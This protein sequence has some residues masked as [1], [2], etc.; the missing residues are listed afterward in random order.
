VLGLGPGDP[1]EGPPPA[2]DAER[3]AAEPSRG[4][5]GANVLLVVF[6]AARADHLGCYGYRQPT[7]PALDRLAAEGVLFERHFT[8][9]VFT[10][11]AM[12][13]LWS[14]R[15]PDEGELRWR[16]DGRLPGDR[17]TLAE[18]LASH[19]ILTAAFVT[20]PSA[21]PSYGLVRGFQQVQLLY[22][23]PWVERAMLPKA[24]VFRKH[25]YPWLEQ[26]RRDRFFVYAHWR[27]PHGPLDEPPLTGPDAPLPPEAHGYQW[28]HPVNAGKRSLSPA[29]RDHLERLYDGNLA[30]A[31]REFGA[32]RR[33][34]EELGL[35]DH[36]VV[37]ATADHGEALLEHGTYGHNV[38]VYQESM[39]IPL[40]VRFPEGAGPAGRRVSRLT[41]LLDIAPTVA[42]LFGLLGRGGS[43]RAFEGRSLLP[44]AIGPPEGPGDPGLVARTVTDVYGLVQGHH[45]LVYDSRNGRTEL[46][47]LEVDPRERV[48]LSGREPIRAAACREALESWLMRV[49]R[50]EG[51]PVEAARPDADELKVLKALGYVK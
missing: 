41:S 33:K 24:A 5:E 11:A 30:Y 18:L 25:L 49:R 42:D 26:H 15:Y 10:Y 9:A 34:L 37:I 8:P 3:A 31:D 39:H 13:S 48:D 1:L 35:W 44:A 32:L 23:P 14:S 50:P 16:P 43:D 36:T 45:K 17:L 21:G 47:D 40:I 38:Q 19:G 29:E 20:N 46:Y 6:D 22:R 51:G 27:E 12:G 4:L 7:T 2:P 28:F